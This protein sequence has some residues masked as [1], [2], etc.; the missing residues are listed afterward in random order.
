MRKPGP[1]RVFHGS[2]MQRNHSTVMRYRMKSGKKRMK[3]TMLCR[4]KCS[5]RNQS[6]TSWP[7][8]LPALARQSCAMFQVLVMIEAKMTRPG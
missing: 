6:I 7:F 2:S 4:S 1:M 5:V 3:E 8:G